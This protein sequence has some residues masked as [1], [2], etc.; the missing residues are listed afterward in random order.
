MA[1]MHAPDRNL[2]MELVR[3][4]DPAT[5]HELWPIDLVIRASTGPVKTRNAA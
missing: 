3:G 2:A 5:I 1:D 4:R